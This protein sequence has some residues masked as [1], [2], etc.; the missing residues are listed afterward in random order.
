MS[1]A[2]PAHL[3]PIE[4]A[5]LEQAAQAA[6]TARRNQP[7]GLLVASGVLLLAMALYVLFALASRNSAA[8]AM[9]SAKARAEEAVRYAGELKALRAMAQT[10]PGATAS[11]TQLRSRLEQAGV[12]SGLS[13]V[14][15]LPNERT[16]TLIPGLGSRQYKYDYELTDP[17]L[18]A[19]LAWVERAVEVVPGLEVYGIS[20]R[21]EANHWRL[22]VT[23]SR[24]QKTE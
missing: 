8:E 3:A 16:E 15:P 9:E 12:E 19:L 11:A 17:N 21:P 23:F 13:K 4:D 10:N 18:A 1:R 7:R 5:R 20:L 24:W 6:R 14:V 2:V 22:R